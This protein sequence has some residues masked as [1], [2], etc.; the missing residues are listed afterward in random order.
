MR[1]G[2]LEIQIMAGLARLQTDMDNAQ[3]MVGG[4]MSNVERS[5]AS[6]K[7][8][9]Q[10]LGVGIPAAMIVDQVRRMTDQYTKLDAQLQLSTKSQASY[11]QGMADI[12]RISTTA[13]A[14]LGATS[15]LYTRLMNVM[16]GTGV[17]QAKLAT[18]TETVSFGLKAYGATAQEASSAALQLSQAM[19]ANRLGGE[20]F[21][22]VME[23]MPNVMKVLAQSMGVPLGELRALSIAGKI[24]ADEMV[25]A[26][27]NP[28]I[29]AEFKRLA[30]NAQT[31]TGAW[32]VARNELM[33][34]VGEFMKSSG[35]TGGIIAGFNGV[36]I[37]IRFLADNMSVLLNAFYAYIT[38]MGGK[39]IIGLVA[40]R[41]AQMSLAAAN[42]AAAESAL[43]AAKANLA[44]AAAAARAGGSAALA[45]V[46]VKEYAVS[47][48]ALAAAEKA[49]AASSIG[50]AGKVKGAIGM[51]GWIGLAL[52]GVWTVYDFL[53]GMQAVA[54]GADKLKA[55]LSEL[56]QTQLIFA[57]AK[58]EMAIRDME[59]AWRGKDRYRVELRDANER[60]KQ[61]NLQIDANWA[62]KDAEYAASLTKKASIALT[63]DEIVTQERMV[64]LA[65]QYTDGKLK[66]AEYLKRVNEELYGVKAAEKAAKIDDKAAKELA[67]SQAKIAIAQI[68]LDGTVALTDAQKKLIELGYEQAQATLR[69]SD[70]KYAEQSSRLSEL[71]VLEQETVAI[72]KLRK[73]NDEFDKA[74]TKSA[75]ERKK[76]FQEIFAHH[77]AAIDKV[78][79]VEKEDTERIASSMSAALVKGVRDSKGMFAAIRDII[80]EE[81]IDKPIQKELTVVI[82]AGVD[83]V[84][85]MIANTFAT[86][87]NTAAQGAG[88]AG[89]LSG[90]GAAAAYAVAAYT[91]YKA[92]D[93]FFG[94]GQSKHALGAPTYEGTLSRGGF[95]GM[96]RQGYEE[97]MGAFSGGTYY[98]SSLSALSSAQ[99]KKIADEVK[100]LQNTFGALGSEIG[101]L[102]VG[103]RNWSAKISGVTD[104]SAVLADVMGNNLL[105][106]LEQFRQVGE[107][108]AQTAQ[109]LTTVFGATNDFIV[110]LGMSS[111]QA[112]GAYGIMSTSQRE[113]LISASGGIE[114]FSQGSSAF[115]QSILTPAQQLAIAYDEVGRVFAELN[116]VGVETKEQFA[117]LVADQLG[118]GEYSVVGSL[119]GVSGAFAKIADSANAAKAAM[120]DINT[121]K[122]MVDYKRAMALATG[123]A[124][125]GG[126]PTI[127]GRGVLTTAQGAATV[128]ASV[129]GATAALSGTLAQE[130][131]ANE[132]AARRALKEKAGAWLDKLASTGYAWRTPWALEGVPEAGIPGYDPGTMYFPAWLA[133]AQATYK[134]LPAF[135]NGGEFS[136]GLRIVGENGPEIE[137]T[138]PSRITSNSDSRKLLDNSEV[139]AELRALRAEVVRLLN[140]SEVTANNSRKTS[141]LLRNVSRDG[142]SLLTE[143]A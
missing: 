125:P 73:I 120:L 56:T 10:T 64:E 104:L 108:L 93:M 119:L 43:F 133:N 143:A 39:F 47:V 113:Q 134:A 99:T 128:P 22:A 34:L 139:V 48:A 82:S 67:A 30:E 81:I 116:V 112:F 101:D 77:Q 46:A 110:A 121:F 78:I 32:V 36:G 72:E 127:G 98:T 5:V 59:N 83:W 7:R 136:G 4:A 111:Q 38:V 9:M 33:L 79:E 53:N 131:L 26:F 23:A 75:D 85:A 11:A 44:G 130:Q 89:G 18:V 97:D 103:T 91:V 70:A 102:G 61:L 50:I 29:A 42:V 92:A 118:K 141:D 24:T 52:F 86:E 129:A 80:T 16:D 6:A 122:T 126:T 58:E 66:D 105:P 74:Q 14:D 107:N 84:K 114:K 41:I 90:I 95:S 62:L 124:M 19:G 117:A 21:R 138:G 100:V 88:K 1:V 87:K 94:V 57:A 17:S 20:E 12:R 71:A 106:A 123:A 63:H 37:A 3:R 137:M 132:S 51:T 15:M 109:R 115:I 135:A 40:A 35:A 2:T 69:V 31:I 28:A 76:R 68:E 60:L 55:K 25:K 96:M 65:K 49:Q 13:Q 54:D 27:G 140:V 142:Q 8:A 45:S